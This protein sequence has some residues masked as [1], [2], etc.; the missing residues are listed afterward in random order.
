MD[1]EQMKNYIDTCLEAYPD[2][3]RILSITGGECM[4]IE[5]DVMRAIEYA[6]SKGI[7]TYMIMN[8]FW[9]KSYKN[10]YETI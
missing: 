3:L 7:K 2:S 10:A 4:L 6:S 9:D 1:F 5:E 8:C